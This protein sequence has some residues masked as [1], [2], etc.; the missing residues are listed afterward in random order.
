MTLRPIAA[1]VLG[2]F[3][4]ACGTAEPRPT[5]S[6]SDPGPYPIPP[7]VPIEGGSARA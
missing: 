5:T 7:N 2:S 6:E 3:L 1:I 4:L